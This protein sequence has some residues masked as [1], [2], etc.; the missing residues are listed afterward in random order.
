MYIRAVSPLTVTRPLFKN[1]GETT[2]WPTSGRSY[3]VGERF[4]VCT[5]KV[6]LGAKHIVAGQHANQ[7]EFSMTIARIFKYKS[8][9]KVISSKSRDAGKVHKELSVRVCHK[10][11]C[12]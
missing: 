1:C 8:L 10:D 3:F 5:N 4:I 11:L 6:M 12:K 2:G 7:I 9:R